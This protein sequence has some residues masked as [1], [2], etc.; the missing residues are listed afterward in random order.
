MYRRL[1]E[2][3]LALTFGI[4]VLGAFVRLS[5]AGLGCPD[6]PGCYGHIT[7]PDEAHEI[8]SAEAKFPHQPVEIKKGWIEMIHRYFA[9]TLGLV[10]IAIAVL[11]WR[12]RLDLRQPIGLPLVLVLL[13]VFQGMLGMWTVTLRLYPAVV[14]AHLIG[15]MTTL[16]SLTWLLMRQYRGRMASG[17]MR[18]SELRPFALLALAVLG[19][20]ILLGG[21][22]STNY[23][24]L[25][26]SDFPLCHGSFTPAAD[27]ANGF[28]PFRDLGRAASGELLH[29][30]ALNAIHWVHRI[31][32]LITF[33]VVG[34]FGLRLLRYAQLKAFAI[35]LLIALCLQIGFGIANVWLSLPLPIAVAHNAVAAVLLVLLVA[36]NFRIHNNN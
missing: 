13:V 6:W 15:G 17:I 9:S 1:I 14:T 4:V 18:V 30:D 31:G 2:I 16:A 32:A 10:I 3:A 34:Y 27:Y 7:V 22:V 23:A 20:Q 26:C 29:Q 12:K 21:W 36:V 5:D 11:A 28:Y 25:A 33:C 24:A 8:A 35:A 19:V